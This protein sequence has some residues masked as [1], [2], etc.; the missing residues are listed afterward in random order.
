[1]AVLNLDGQILRYYT[2]EKDQEFDNVCVAVTLQGRVMAT[3]S[4]GVWELKPDGTTGELV[5]LDLSTLNYMTIG[6][7]DSLYIAVR[8]N[9]KNRILRVSLNGAT[10][11]LVTIDSDRISD[12]DFD[13]NGNLFMADAQHGR[14]LKYSQ[15]QGVE[16][17]SSGFS[18]GG[19]PFLTFDKAGRLYSSSSENGLALVSAD[20]T[21]TP[22]EFIN[23]S[24]ELVFHDGLL[25]ALDIYTSTLYEINVDNT[26]I[27][28]KRILL[29][30]AVPW[31]IDLQGEIIVGE[32]ACISGRNFF[33]YDINQPGHVE[34]NSLLNTLQPNQ[35][36][37]DDSGN[38]YLLFGSVLKKLDSTGEEEFSVSLP[39]SFLW[40]TRIFY[41]PSDDNIYYFD[42]NSNSVVRANAQGAETYHRF[43]STVSRAFLSITREGKIYAGVISSDGAKLVDISN[44][45]EERV[46]WRPTEPSAES[47][48]YFH[49][50]SDAEG[51]LY[52]ALGPKFQQVFCVD[53]VA[54]TA[55]SV[56]DESATS[57]Y[58]WG[59]VDPQ[60]FTVTDS[61]T[62]VLS[63][64]GVLIAFIPDVIGPVVKAN[65]ST[66]DISIDSG[67]N[68]SIALQINPGEY[69]GA[70]V[71]WWVVARA[72]GTWYYLDSAAGWTQFDGNFSNCHPVTQGA[73][74]NL[75]ATEVLNMTGLS[76][77]SYTFYFVVDYPM[78]GIL[79]LN[80][81]ILVDSVNVTV[82]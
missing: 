48:C 82:Q 80:G 21:V 8:S 65:G 50:G 60:G 54:G 76:A 75:P 49:V 44:P 9:G 24:G 32:R 66:D 7:D 42:E 53:P 4:R 22:L 81:P 36:A 17:F 59:F 63:A 57:R 26:T 33:N 5:R 31:Y 71:D 34:P 70:E 37:F 67:D 40:N 15:A 61:G 20:G 47:F 13:S 52:A 27:L 55:I 23:I 12:M 11:D 29:E 73:L 18:S 51:N 19:T 28:S 16:I 10:N 77:G 3:S 56:F 25:Y 64:P 46:I 43:S 72:N 39:G 6:P 79:N 14:I 38:I 30:G 74:F 1:M 68:L 58:D 35:Y 41:N 69:S 62:V 78:D 45:P 2:V